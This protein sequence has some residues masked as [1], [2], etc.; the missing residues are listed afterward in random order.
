M[1]RIIRPM[2]LAAAAV[3]L[4]SCATTATDGYA[5][6]DT[7]DEPKA[8]GMRVQVSYPADWTM[9]E[10]Q[11]RSTIIRTFR[12]EADGYNTHLLL[13]AMALGE[14]AG[15]LFGDEAGFD[16]SPRRAKWIH[17]LG[18][19]SGTQ[20]GGLKALTH[21]GRPAVMVDLKVNRTGAQSETYLAS[22]MLMVQDKGNMLILT[23]GVS[24]S[25]SEQE[26]V[27]SLQ[28]IHEDGLCCHYFDSLKFME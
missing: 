23:C 8:L 10:D 19:V 2:V 24:A 6:Y 11:A 5:V 9:E 16:N 27:D 25:A 20:V 21:A 26:K 7:V 17:V 1:M 15:I 28:R 18:S 14:D 12:H 4:A 3:L 22:R 13:Q